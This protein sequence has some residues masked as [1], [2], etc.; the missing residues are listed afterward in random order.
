M[1]AAVEGFKTGQRVI[2]LPT[3]YSGAKAG[4]IHEVVVPAEGRRFAVVDCG[5]GHFCLRYFNQ[6]ERVA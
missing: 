5:D 6:L 1:N 4:I 2:C 3:F